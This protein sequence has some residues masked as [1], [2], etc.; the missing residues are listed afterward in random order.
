MRFLKKISR[1]NIYSYFL[2]LSEMERIGWK[3]FLPRNN[4]YHV[5]YSIN[6]KNKIREPKVVKY[7]LKTK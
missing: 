4:L 7:A 3:E 2:N 1:K 5:S 6:W